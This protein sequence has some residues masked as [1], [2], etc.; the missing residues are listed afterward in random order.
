MI[1]PTIAIVAS[2]WCAEPRR[3]DFAGLD[4]RA[5]RERGVDVEREVER[6]EVGRAEREE[7]ARAADP[8]F[9]VV[10]PA[11]AD[12][13]FCFCGAAISVRNQWCDWPAMIS[14]G[15]L[16]SLRGDDST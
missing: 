16:M 15:S 1:A 7:D 3:E 12:A 11:L 13:F 9:A 6:E 8:R 4:A 5:L 2:G 10:L 14:R